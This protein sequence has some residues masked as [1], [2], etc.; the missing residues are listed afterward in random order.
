MT[1][2]IYDPTTMIEVDHGGIRY[3]LEYTPGCTGDLEEPPSDGSF[4]VVNMTVIDK[5]EAFELRREEVC[6]AAREKLED[7]RENLE[8]E[9]HDR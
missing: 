5:Q 8:L 4:E 1:S 2:C 3:F 7:E 9:R 6:D